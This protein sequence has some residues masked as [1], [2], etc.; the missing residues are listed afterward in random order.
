M[1]QARHSLTGRYKIQ[2]LIGAVIV[3]VSVLGAA[4]C[5]A[6]DAGHA[7]TG[8]PEAAE[9]L[10]PNGDLRQTT[11]S[12]DQ[13]PPFMD[14]KSE[15]MQLIYKLAAA[16]HELLASMP[17]YCG[18]GESAGHQNNLNCFVAEIEEDGAVVWDDHGTRCG[19]CL[20]IAVEAS[21]LKSEGMSDIDIRNAIDE[22]YKEGYAEPTPTP[23]PAA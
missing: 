10:M 3:T 16:N 20:N 13:L 1:F 11:A 7:V 8:K 21:K 17:C 18:C 6:G 22:K 14:D 12:A 4:G 9:R 5:S 15:E 19:V 2:K 23:M